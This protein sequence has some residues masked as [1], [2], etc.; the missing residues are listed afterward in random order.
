MVQLLVRSRA[1]RQGLRTAETPIRS[2][3]GISDAAHTAEV[4]AVAR[5]L[6]VHCLGREPVG[7]T[8]NTEVA[9]G[10]VVVV[11]P[12]RTWTAGTTGR[13]LALRQLDSF[14]ALPQ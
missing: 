6:V 4:E 10:V 5:T 13:P 14:A 11:V 1:L 3:F 9:A 2:G 8:M 7:Y 12:R